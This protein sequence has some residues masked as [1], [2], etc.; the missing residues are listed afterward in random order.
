MIIGVVPTGDES[1]SRYED[2]SDVE[3]DH[4]QEEQQDYQTRRS[5]W[6]QNL[7]VYTRRQKTENDQVQGE[8][9]VTVSKN[10]E[11][12]VQPDV[13]DSSSSPS[14]SD[15]T[16]SAPLDDLDIPIAQRK[17]SRSTVGKLPSHLSQYDISNYMSYS[18][19]GPQYRAFIAALDSAVPIPHDWQEAKRHP[20]WRAAM[21]EEMAALDKNN[22]WELSTLPTGKK[23]VGCKWVF[24][25]KHKPDGKVERYKAR[26]VAKGYNQTYGVDYDETFAPVAKMNTIKTLIS[27]AANL[28]WKLFQLDVKNAFLHGDLQEEVYMEI[29]PGFNTRMTEGKVCK[30]KKSLY[31]LKQSPRAWFG[32]FRKE[33]CNKGFLQSNAD[34]TLFYKNHQGRIVILIVYVDDII[35][36]GNDEREMVQLKKDL[37]RSFEV[38]DLGHLHYFLGIEVAYST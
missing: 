10:P 9:E 12:Q 26:L 7:K 5:R 15:G 23:A 11:V 16:I 36:T 1:D 18:S 19:V 21:L 32:K 38:K 30:L 37:A 13:Y 27:I 25:I 8:E 33:I 28:R 4:T 2:T 24:T 34:H 35:I 6:P 14:T 22:T 20:Q 17:Q 29:P 3:Q 31:G